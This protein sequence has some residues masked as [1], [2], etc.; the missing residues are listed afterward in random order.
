MKH[1]LKQSV[2][3]HIESNSLT[4]N[5]LK[6]LQLLST[7]EKPR[8][9]ARNLIYPISIV[10]AFIAFVLAFLLTPLMVE[11][12]DVRELVAIEVVTNHLKLKPLEIK[13][14]SIHDIRNYFTKLDFLPMKS[15]LVS[16]EGLK[17]I[18]GR[19]CSL[20]GISAAQLRVR[21]SESSPIQTLY[22]TEYR[23]DIFKNIPDLEQGDV[24]VSIYVKGIKVKI[25]TE[26]GLLFVLTDT[27]H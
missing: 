15:Q 20:Q 16:N 4:E 7:Q 5:Q 23:K 9:Y 19:Y 8:K 25:W 21:K 6:N 22:Q 13:T 1:L 12:G 14:N 10:A 3:D 11:Q 27:T 2:R 18:G 17:L 24:P 26:K